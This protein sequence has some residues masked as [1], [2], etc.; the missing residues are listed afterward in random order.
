M[1][2]IAGII[3]MNFLKIMVV[4]PECHLVTPCSIRGLTLTDEPHRQLTAARKEELKETKQ[5][6]QLGSCGQN[7][8]RAAPALRNLPAAEI[9]T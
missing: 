9:I 5:H 7:R 8:H 2:R 1:L 3:L 6:Q 4:K